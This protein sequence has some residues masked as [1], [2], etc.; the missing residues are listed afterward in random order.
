MVD[1]KKRM[2]M[3]LCKP[4]KFP[5]PCFHGR[6]G[7]EKYIKITFCFSFHCTNTCPSVELGA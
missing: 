2:R 5:K 3:I 7:G 6:A 1:P 4:L